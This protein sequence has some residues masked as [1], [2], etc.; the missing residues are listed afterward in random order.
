[1][2]CAKLSAPIEMDG[3]RQAH[4][5]CPVERTYTAVTLSQEQSK[6]LVGLL[7]G[8]SVGPARETQN[9]NQHYTI[10]STEIKMKSA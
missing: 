6:G 7:A 9:H 4:G 8:I 5:M 3:I 2:Y 1:M 10:Q